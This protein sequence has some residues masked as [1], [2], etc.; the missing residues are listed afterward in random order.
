[1]TNLFVAVRSSK[2]HK[3]WKRTAIKTATK[4]CTKS[5]TRNALARIVF[6]LDPACR[7]VKFEHEQPP[8]SHQIAPADYRLEWKKPQC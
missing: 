8:N 6:E 4:S 3:S 2:M 1:M 5:A 7:E